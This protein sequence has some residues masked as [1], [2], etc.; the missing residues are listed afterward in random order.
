MELKRYQERVVRE[1]RAFLDALVVERARVGNTHPILDAWKTATGRPFPHLERQ[2][3]IGEDLPTFCIKVPTGGG[4]TLLATQILGEI[5]ASLLRARNGTGLAL[6]VVPSDQ[7]YKDTLSALRDPRNPYRERLEF[8]LKNRVEVWEKHEVSRLTPGRLH[9]ALNVLVI[10]LASANRETKD[11]L[12][13]FQDSGGNIVQHFPSEDDGDAQRALKQRI[14]NLDMISDDLA[15]T[16]LANLLR[17]CKPAV[18]LDEGHKAYSE[19]AQKTIEGF[20]A[21]IVVELS[22]TPKQEANVLSRVSGKELLDEEMIKLPI[23]VATSGES[24]WRTCLAKAKDRREDLDRL[25]RSIGNDERTIRPIVLVQVERTGEAQRGTD[26]IH[27][28]DVKEHLIGR[29]GIHEAAIAIKSSE[30]DDIE[31]LKLL[32][33]GC[34]TTWI[35]TKSALQEG[36]DCPFAYILVSLA[37]TQSKTGLT[38]LVGRVLRQPFAKRTSIPELNESYVFCLRRDS[39]EIL[40]EVKKA[41][42]NEGYE[43]QATSVVDASKPGEGIG[44]RTSRIRKAYQPIYRTFQGKVYLPRFCVKAGKE[45]EGLDYFRHLIGEV[46]VDGFEVNATKWDLRTAAKAASDLVYRVQLG[47]TEMETV[48]REETVPIEND[49]QV[50]RW[51][52]A[53]LPFEHFSHRQL[54]RVVDRV[55]AD[56]LRRDVSLVN[57][58]A[59]VRFELRQRIEGLIEAE[60]DKQTQGTFTELHRTDKLCFYLECVQCRFEMPPELELRA[61]RQLVHADNSRVQRSLFDAVP[62]DSLN[63][64]EKEIALFLDRH[65]Q[66]LWWYRNEVGPQHFS[67]QGYKRARIYPDFVVQRGRAD[68]KSKWKPTPSV[69]VV[70]SKGEHLDGNLDTLYKRDIARS[71]EELGKSVTWQQLGAGFANSTFRFQVLAGDRH[72][73]WKGE[74]QAILKV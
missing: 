20:N 44:K 49:D 19:L 37:N 57:R 72:E 17:M 24:N 74:L 68:S 54:R 60:T 41:L 5:H 56:V 52:S 70:E 28:E 58:L 40:A 34:L 29:L 14:P 13:M 2:N 63:S 59:L 38:Q 1:V 22:A 18:I 21:S 15:R 39:S 61:T 55:C 26:Y 73:A 36:W 33:S 23:N 35:I 4:K 69:L 11:Q 12:K 45:Y 64:Y 6:W 42:E 8:A 25:A 48:R 31:G 43:G 47:S 27:S 51:L 67:I 65:D 9:S 71:F 66:V 3:A 50:R 62:E 32:D 53:N 10:K 30:K 46:D 7:I 16:S